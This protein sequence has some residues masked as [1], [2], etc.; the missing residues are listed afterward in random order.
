LLWLTPLLPLAV[1]GATVLGLG[2]DIA[3]YS[4]LEVSLSAA[5]QV[6][7]KVLLHPELD[8]CSGR[9]ESRVLGACYR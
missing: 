2:E 7:Q 3:S 4:S 9:N 8:V 5:G 1:N 6:C